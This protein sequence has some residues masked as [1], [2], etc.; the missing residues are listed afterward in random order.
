MRLSCFCLSGL[1]L[2]ACT[3]NEAIYR[4][5]SFVFGT[6][7][8]ISI[9][10]ENR[11]RSEIAAN[12][13]LQRFD[14]LHRKLHAWQPSELERLN[15]AFANGSKEAAVDPELLRILEETK[16]LSL[17]SSELFNPAIGNLIRLWGFHGDGAPG[18]V[19]DKAEIDR[20]V[21]ARPSM[22]DIHIEHARVWS[23]NPAVR[24]DLGGYAKGYALDLAV[25][26]LR[27]HGIRNALV[28]IGGNVIA[29]GK[30]GD[31]AWKVG[32]Q[33]PRRAGV[34]ATLDLRDGEAIGT[35]GDYQRYFEADGKRYCHLIDPRTGWPA[36]GM[37]SVTLLVSGHGAGV[38]SDVLTKPLFLGDTSKLTGLMKH[39]RLNELLV[40]DANGKVLTSDAMLK[41]LQWREAGQSYH[42][43]QHPAVR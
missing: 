36:R 4:Q 12:S 18:T 8:E 27:Q 24:I 20:L 1:L 29:L 30:H 23:D 37:Q 42:L 16:S 19:P 2:H 35:S 17:Q 6:R 5:E 38:K 14:A 34:I 40:I 43:L 41:R 33:H 7:V 21:A 39:L 32:I 15:A 31:R 9:H 26:I 13:V 25:L 11:S 28:N 3:K 22:Q 10:G